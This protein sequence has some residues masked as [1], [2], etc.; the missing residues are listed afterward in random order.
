MRQTMAAVIL[1]CSAL[2]LFTRL[3]HYA[4]WDDEAVT[5]LAGKGVWRTGDTSVILDH[6]VVAYRGGLLLNGTKERSTPPLGAYLAAPF[7]GLFD[8]STFAAR[9]PFAFLGLC[10]VGLMVWW[11]HTASASPV[12]WIVFGLAIIGNVSMWLYDR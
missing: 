4:L 2:L 1:F 6:N 10:S 12:T 11:L 8:G 7:V 9:F 3:G 5:A